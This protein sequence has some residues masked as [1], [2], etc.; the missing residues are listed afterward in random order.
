MT[1]EQ[2]QALERITAAATA[3]LAK[4]GDDA[5]GCPMPEPDVV[6]DML[7]RLLTTK[8]KTGWRPLAKHRQGD[9]LGAV[10][11]ERWK[12]HTGQGS[13]SLWGPMTSVHRVDGPTFQLADSLALCLAIL[14][15][16]DRSHSDR[17]ARAMGNA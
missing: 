1:P 15:G 12:W 16:Q 4:L 13:A 11:V 3:A 17:W 2:E 7:G 9:E 6:R 14:T 8:G 5:R 10:L